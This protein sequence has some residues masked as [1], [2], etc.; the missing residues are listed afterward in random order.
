VKIRMKVI[1]RGAEFAAD[2]GDVLDVSERM[3]EA[4]VDGGAA[5]LIFDDAPKA[6][7][8]VVAETAEAPAAD[9]TATVPRKGKGKR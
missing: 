8:P 3:A 7:A 6:S 4:L 5:D 2:P 9:E 1:A